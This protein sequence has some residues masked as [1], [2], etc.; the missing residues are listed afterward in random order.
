[1]LTLESEWLK[2]TTE[3]PGSTE[4][5]GSDSEMTDDTPQEKA[6]ST[7]AGGLVS[8]QDMI[9]SVK[10]WNSALLERVNQLPTVIPL[11]SLSRPLAEM[12]LTDV[13]L[14]GQYLSGFGSGL[15]EPHL[16]SHEKIVCFLPDVEVVRRNKVSCRRVTFRGSSGTMHKY[17]IHS[18]SPVNPTAFGWTEQRTWTLMYHINRLL[19]KDKNSRRRY[20][21]LHSAQPI[22]LSNTLRLVSE[23]SNYISLEDVYMEHCLRSKMNADTPLIRYWEQLTT[24]PSH[25]VTL[26]AKMSAFKHVSETLVPNDVLL[27]FVQ[28]ICPT[29]NEFYQFRKTMATQLG[30]WGLM[31]HLLAVS[32]SSLHK[33]LIGQNTGELLHF[34]FHP[35]FTHDGSMLAPSA[36]PFR[37][38]RNISTLLSPFCIEGT[39][40]STMS[41]ASFGLAQNQDYLRDLL[42]LFIRDELIAWQSVRAGVMDETFSKNEDALKSKVKHNVDTLLDRVSQLS[43]LHPDRMQENAPEVLSGSDRRSEVVPADDRVADLIRQAMDPEQLCK[44]DPTSHP[45]F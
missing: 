8:L 5:D 31:S 42:L 18:M 9:D 14:P 37:L 40:L 1:M 32:D 44:L 27:Q 20:L 43:P 15:Q 34:K 33:V 24:C 10:K 19:E 23:R 41:V 22:V 12:Q 2:K 21:R 45:W 36:V 13:E 26:A 30:M 39:V 28:S 35:K 4:A 16:E 25:R 7:T 6:S 3:S 17:L 29:W 38:T 11:E